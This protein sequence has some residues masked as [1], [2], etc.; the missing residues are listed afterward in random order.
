[1]SYTAF[2][3]RKNRRV[4]TTGFDTHESVLNE[5]LY[6]FQR[7][8]VSW[9]LNRGRAALF[10]DCGLGKTPQQLEWAHH[11]SEYTAKP[12]LIFAPLAVSEQTTKEGSKFGAPV[13]ICESG[14]DLRD[15]VN[16]TNY[17]KL[18]RFNPEK[19]GGVVLDESSILKNYAGHYRNAL[20]EFVRGL[21]F[22]L[23]C[24]ATPAPNDLAEII[25]HS[26][27]LGVM[28][29]KEAIALYFIQDGNTTHKW[30]LK[31]H[32]E[33]PFWKWLS[34]W[35]VAI[36]SPKDIGFDGTGFELPELRVIEHTVDAGASGGFLFA[37]EAQTLQERRDARRES[38]DRRVNLCAELVNQSSEPWLLWCDLNAESEALRRAIPDAVEVKGADSESHKVDAMTGFSEGRYRVLVTKP[39]I[40]G[41]GMNWQHCAKM[42]FVGLSDSWEA[43]YQAVRRCWRYGQTRPVEAHVIISE[44][45][46]AVVSN[47]QRK[48]RNA[49]MM[50]EQMIRA[51]QEANDARC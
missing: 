1:M 7:H 50:F 28:T 38:K 22:R 15:G 42:A 14:D 10:E 47:I 3:E 9:A 33:R 8:I 31:G 46:G 2:L 37:V 40:A 43:Y 17:E 13:N 45:E 5:R 23:A 24:T 21:Q 26:E 29:G 34:E 18:H 41:F 20:T 35:A 49:A 39:S 30:R 25:N 11:V 27:F 12:V 16:I 6:P 36:R 19:L 51:M 32:A 4:V 48:E 44:A